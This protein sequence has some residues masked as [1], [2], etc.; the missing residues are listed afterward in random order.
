MIIKSLVIQLRNSLWIEI[1]DIIGTPQNS[2]WSNFE[3][4][5]SG[6]PFRITKR[7]YFAYLAYTLGYTISYSILI[8]HLN[9]KGLIRAYNCTWSPNFPF[10][11]N[12][13]AMVD[14][15]EASLDNEKGIIT[16]LFKMSLI[17]VRSSGDDLIFRWIDPFGSVLQSITAFKE[18]VYQL[19]QVHS[20]VVQGNSQLP[21]YRYVHKISIRL[22]DNFLTWLMPNSQNIELFMKK[23]QNLR[24]IWQF[25]A[26]PTSGKVARNSCRFFSSYRNSS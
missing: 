16:F 2:Q 20:N 21:N 8:S 13:E 3:R 11:F 6:I 22:I 14:T 9:T 4:L 7:T 19:L 1:K 26:S 15:A 25:K 24:K 10:C 18:N 23:W 5:Y 12:T 17:H